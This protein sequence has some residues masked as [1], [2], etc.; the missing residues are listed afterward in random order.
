MRPMEWGK[1]RPF[2]FLKAE[3]R[4]S[5]CRARLGGHFITTFPGMSA[6]VCGSMVVVSRARKSK[7]K[8]PSVSYFGSGSWESIRWTWIFII[9]IVR[10]LDHCAKIDG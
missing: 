10:D 4:G 1:M 9:S 3:L 6:S 5:I 2:V 8:L 7:A